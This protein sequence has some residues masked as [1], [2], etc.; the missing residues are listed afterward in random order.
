MAAAEGAPEEI[1]VT[2][3]GTTV[4]ITGPGEV[5]VR[6]REGALVSVQDVSGTGRFDW[7]SYST[8]DSTDGLEYSVTDA[9]AD[10]RLDTKIGE[11]A[12]FVNLGGGW[13]QLEKRGDQLGAVVDG[14]WRPLQ[15]Q[16]KLFRVKSP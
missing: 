6:S 16:G 14:E 5:H 13:S 15:R 2:R 3:N 10:G 8:I 11:H 9:D 1:V 7:I 4:S 12:S